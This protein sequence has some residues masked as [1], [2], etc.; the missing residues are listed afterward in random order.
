MPIRRTRTRRHQRRNRYV[1]ITMCV[2]V[3]VGAYIVDLDIDVG[4]TRTPPSNTSD[5]QPTLPIHRLRSNRQRCPPMSSR[6]KWRCFY[7]SR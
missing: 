4:W 2:S 7:S 1:G 5:S 3:C 6:S